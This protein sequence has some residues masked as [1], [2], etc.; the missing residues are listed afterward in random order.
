[1][2]K[3]YSPFH[4]AV[5][6]AVARVIQAGHKEGKE[7][8]MCGE[9]AGEERAVPLLVGMGLDEFSMVSNEIAAVRYQVRGLSEKQTGHL[10]KRVLA[11]GTEQE[12][13]KLLER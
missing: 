6:R 9:F 4:P 13:R 5:L 7:V 1:M 11:A 3:L 12:I 2:T 8:G 10:A